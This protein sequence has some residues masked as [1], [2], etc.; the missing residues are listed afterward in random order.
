M[1]SNL[2]SRLLPQNPQGRS[3]YD[4]LRAHDE[5][6]DLE[7]QAGLALDEENLGFRDDELGAADDF[8]EHSRITTESTAFLPSNQHNIGGGSAPRAKLQSRWMAQSPRLMDEDGDDDVPASLLIEGNELPGPSSPSKS[9][10]RTGKVPKRHAA[11]PGPSNRETRAHWEAAQAQQRLHREGDASPGLPQP[12]RHHF[13]PLSGSAREKAMWRWI[14]VVNLDGFIEEVYGYYTGAGIW[15]IV[16]DRAL[17]LAQIIFVA[18]F[19]TFLTQCVDYSAI[20]RSKKLSQVLVPQCT[21]NI[22]GMPNVAIWLFTL[23]IFWRVYQLLIDIPRLLR[24]RDFFVHLLE[25]PDGDMQT[26]S[27]Q[28]VVA[29][30]MALRDANPIT[31]ENISPQARKYLGSQSKQRLDAHDIANRLMRKENYLIAMFNKDILDLTLPFPFLQ[32]RQLFSRTLL[33]NLDWCVMGLIF[34]DSGQVRQLILKDSHRRQLS[35]ALRGRFLFAGFMNVIFAPVIV[36]YLMIVY[37]LRYF[38]EYK[39]DPSA[40]GSRQYTPLAEWKFRE[41]NELHHLFHKRVNMSYPFAS[42]YLDQ[43]PKVKS[44]QLARF[45]SFIAGA[46]VSV[47]AVATLWDPESFLSFD[48]TS[49]RTVLFYLTVFGGIWAATNGMIPEENLVF[50]PEYALRQV[51][52]YTHY[53]PT[54]WQNRLHSD[55]VKREFATL[56]Q[57]KIIIFLE[58]VFSIIVTPFILWFSLPKCS[59][60]IIDFFREFTI[61]VDGVGYVCSFAVFDFKK[62]DGRK[63]LHHGGGNADIRDEYYSTK[64]GKMAASY[65]G[66]IDNYLLNPKTAL[67]GHV[68]PGQRPHVPP[69]SFPGLMSPTLAAEMQSSRLGRSERRPDPRTPANNLQTSRAPRF[70]PTAIQSSPMQSILLDPHHQPSSFSFGAGGRSAIQHGNANSRSRYKVRTNIIEEPLEDD[71]DEA[72]LSRGNRSGGNAYDSGTGVLEESRWETS[73]TRT[74]ANEAVEEEADPTGGGGVLGLLYQFQKAQNDGRPGVV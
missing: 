63:P 27:W 60:Q 11:I 31:T 29:R 62:G 15:C 58:E 66:F 19:T 52:E 3:I 44:V 23:H 32:D 17:N 33:W 40:I 45:M 37:F 25:V 39:K 28:D 64:H 48:I 38:N 8:G 72:A 16:L 4:D 20:P 68:P 5:E 46:I 54:Q 7:E 10:T 12:A 61:H 65:Y 49:D 59:D 6:S 36:I 43:F 22:S 26:I 50:E 67:Q 13:G 53:M 57:L 35:E 34:N 18:V 71:E 21:K 1:T 42:R 70:A 51:I 74:P 41:F 55:E 24:N 30:I 2:L 47:L 56:Y 9:R 73:P 14:N 69:P